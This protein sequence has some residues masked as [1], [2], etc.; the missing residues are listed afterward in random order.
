M[1]APQII[2]IV[3]FVLGF[4]VASNTELA[5][6]RGEVVRANGLLPQVVKTVIWVALLWWGGFW[7]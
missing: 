6:A 7:N 3:F 5:H 2:I 1:G 4:F